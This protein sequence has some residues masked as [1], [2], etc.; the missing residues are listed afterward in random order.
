MDGRRLSLG[1]ANYKA[2]Y[3]ANNAIKDGCGTE[4]MFACNKPRDKQSN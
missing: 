1:L 2:Y 3:G 4:G